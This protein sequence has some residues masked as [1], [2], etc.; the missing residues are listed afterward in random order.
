MALLPRRRKTALPQR[1]PGAAL[2]PG[3]ILAR[4][5]H[6]HVDALT[7]AVRTY[8]EAGGPDDTP[9]DVR[10]LFAERT[11]IG[12]LVNQLVAV[13]HAVDED[14]TDST[15]FAAHARRLLDDMVL[16]VLLPR[17]VAIRA[18]EIG[19]TGADVPDAMSGVG[20]T[21]RDWVTIA[22][23]EEADRWVEPAA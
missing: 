2:D 4:A 20:Q 5:V 17:L 10:I 12:D 21:L 3:A 11:L 15:S 14:A 23:A 8:V 6:E 13:R 18:D 16:Y 7:A 1:E 22:V 19:L 9:R